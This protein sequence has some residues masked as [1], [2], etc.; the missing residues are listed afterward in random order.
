VEIGNQVG[1]RDI[2]KIAGREGEHVRHEAGHRFRSGEH[3]DRTEDAPDSGEQIQ[4]ECASA[5]I[6]GVQQDRDVTNFLRACRRAADLPTRGRS[7]AVPASGDSPAREVRARTYPIS[8]DTASL[9][10]VA[11][12]DDVRARAKEIRA[13]LGDPETVLL[14]VDRLDYTKGILHRLKAYG[15]LLRER[16]LGPPS[17]VLVQ[18]ASPSRERVEQYQVLRDN[19]YEV[20]HMESKVLGFFAR[21]P[22]ATQK[23]LA[24]ATGQVN[25]EI[26]SGKSVPAAARRCGGSSW[27]LQRTV[28]HIVHTP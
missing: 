20:T 24:G 23:D 8:I 7:V 16:R 1:H 18:V 14:G 17:A 11:R 21:H 19:A 25:W 9:E 10:E 27:Q 5:R 3:C 28:E 26:S 15:E 22:G 6:A 13:E 2:E 4:G 12:R